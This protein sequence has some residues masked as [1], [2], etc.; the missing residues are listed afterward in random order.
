[1]SIIEFVEKS[2]GR[3]RSLRSVHHLAFSHLEEVNSEIEIISL[4]KN[5]PQVI[6]LCQDN[7][8][9]P[10]LA[11]TPFK[12]SWEGESDWDEKEELKGSTIL[13]PIPDHD[14]PLQGRLLRDQGYAETMP[15]VAKY[16]IQEDGTF[17][18]ITQYDRAS[19]E[20]KIWFVNPQLR[21]RVS[22]I[23]TSSGKGATTASFSSE[24]KI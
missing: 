16:T 20:E 14:N 7:N 18:L 11:Q 23:K 3:W 10:N 22:T 8:I 17:V 5:D 4:D 13:V 1:M 15:A 21:F 12:M 24:I 6:S 2:L 9:D 19:A